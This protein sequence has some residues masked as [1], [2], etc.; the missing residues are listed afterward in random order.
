MTEHSM[1][2][3]TSE[4]SRNAVSTQQYKASNLKVLEPHL[5]SLWILSLSALMACKQNAGSDLP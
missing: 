1:A 5:S 2:M 4:L 3:N